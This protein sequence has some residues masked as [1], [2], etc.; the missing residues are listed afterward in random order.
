MVD[1]W[2]AAGQLLSFGACINA[3]RKLCAILP[4]GLQALVMY[5]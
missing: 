5:F 2:D 3:A 4:Y 1:G